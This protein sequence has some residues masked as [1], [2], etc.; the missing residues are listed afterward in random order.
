MV[1]TPPP[2]PQKGKFWVCKWIGFKYVQSVIC[3]HLEGWSQCLNLVYNLC[4]RLSQCWS[5]MTRIFGTVGETP[6]GGVLGQVPYRLSGCFGFRNLHF[7][8]LEGYQKK[9]G[10]ELY[11]WRNIEGRLFN[12]RFGVNSIRPITYSECM[13]LASVIERV[14]R[15]LRIVICCLSVC[16]IFI[17]IFLINY[18][19]NIIGHKM[20]VLFSLQL[21]PETFLILRHFLRNRPVAVKCA[22][23]F[24]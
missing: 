3:Y 10:S 22:L 7:S 12:H 6:T 1:T 18:L 5:L 2:H 4:S 11:I 20:C 19:K 9:S 21:L 23:V 15:M 13:F 14:K 16:G 24:V 8:A 17:H